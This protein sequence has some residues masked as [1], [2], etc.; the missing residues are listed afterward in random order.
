MTEFDETAHQEN[1]QYSTIN[2]LKMRDSDSD[3]ETDTHL[4]AT[5]YP[6]TNESTNP[7]LE[8][9]NTTHVEVIIHESKPIPKLTS[10]SACPFQEETDSEHI[11]TPKGDVQFPHMSKLKTLFHCKQANTY[12]TCIQHRADFGM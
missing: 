12:I 5:E 7:D 9:S 10:R 8:L 2:I 6:Y 3:M 4:L 11:K 1:E